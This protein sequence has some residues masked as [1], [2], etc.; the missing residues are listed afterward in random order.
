MARLRSRIKDNRP[1]RIGLFLLQNLFVALRAPLRRRHRPLS[2][3]TEPS[4]GLAAMIRVKDEARFLPE[5][6]AHHLNVGVEHIYVYDN[7]STDDIERVIAP[8]ISRRD[9]TYVHWPPVPASPAAEY[10]FLARF[11][12]MCRWV[13]FFDA[14]EF[15]Y[16]ARPGELAAVLAEHARRP[17]IAVSWHYFGSAGHEVVP[18][19][20]VTEQFD[21]ADAVYNR[22]VKVIARPAEIVQ[23][24]NSHNFHYRHG[25]L[26]VT[27][28]GQRVFGSFITPPTRPRLVLRHYVYRSR[29]DSRRKVSRGYVDAQGGRELSRRMALSDSEFHRWN[30]IHVPPDPRVIG[31]TASLLRS[32]GCPDELYAAQPVTETARQSAGAA[33]GGPA[34]EPETG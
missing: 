32:L 8:F 4:Y 18:R 33:H 17:A 28:D 23:T 16:E 30:D 12:P 29:E 25:R 2:D 7:N 3:G 19:G 10:D 27:P 31:A 9:V 14:D 13:A 1:A 11:G 34:R 20:L 6:I 24:R 15:L 5:W 26:A 22:H 21:H